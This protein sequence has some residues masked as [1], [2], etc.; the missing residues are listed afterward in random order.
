MEISNHFTSFIR[1][2]NM[3]NLF[4]KQKL[5]HRHRKQTWLPRGKVE[6]EMN[7]EFDTNKYDCI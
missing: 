2:G 5:T 6:G 3:M 1:Q 7:W 4:T